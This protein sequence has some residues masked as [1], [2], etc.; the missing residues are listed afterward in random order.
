MAAWILNYFFLK[1]L[2]QHIK[3]I[4]YFDYFVLAFESPFLINVTIDISYLST[5]SCNQSEY[6]GWAKKSTESEITAVDFMKNYSY[7]H[8]T[9]VFI[10]RI[11]TR[12]CWL[13]Q[14]WYA[15]FEKSEVKKPCGV[16]YCQD[17]RTTPLSIL[18]SS[19]FTQIFIFKLLERP[20][21]LFS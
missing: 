19:D 15:K 1:L 8:N 9:Y 6:M 14:S 3:N 13:F 5:F 4:R 18:K 20:W 16:F 10:T 12:S 7:H 2:S 17:T 11:I 21:M